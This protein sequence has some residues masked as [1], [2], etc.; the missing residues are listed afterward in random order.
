MKCVCRTP[1]TFSFPKAVFIEGAGGHVEFKI[2]GK[3]EAG[4]G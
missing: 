2:K 3:L 1:T 4:H